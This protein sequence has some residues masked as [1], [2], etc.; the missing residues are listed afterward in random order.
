MEDVQVCSN[1]VHVD[2]D[3]EVDIVNSCSTTTRSDQSTQAK[4]RQKNVGMYIYLFCCLFY[5][6][7]SDK[8]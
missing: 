7:V 5:V 8:V 1:D 4:P 6:G 2:D 3:A